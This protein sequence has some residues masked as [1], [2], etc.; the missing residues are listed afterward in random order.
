LCTLCFTSLFD[1]YPIVVAANRDEYDRPSMP[2]ALM[3]GEPKIIAGKDL[4]AGAPG[5]A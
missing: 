4:C 1:A 2:P 3:E 5:S